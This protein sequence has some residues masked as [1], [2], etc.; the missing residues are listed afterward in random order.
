LIQAR[1]QVRI[2]NRIYREVIPRELTW[3]TQIRITHEQAWYLTPERRLDIAKLLAAFQQFFRE[4]SDAWIEG[5]SFK[6][7]GPQLLLQAFLQR[8]VNGGGRINREYGL[9]RK[10]TDL[11][12]E[13]PVD[14]EQGFL[15][16]VQ[17]VVLELKLWKK[18]AL[19]ALIAEGQ[20]Q[21]VDYAR[22]C[23]ADEAHLIVFDR[24]AAAAPWD[25]RIWQ[26][27]ATQDGWSLG[28]WGA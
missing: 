4:N 16:E 14:E 2:A 20:T 27:S 23:G 25:E 22:Q 10:R 5:F 7:A 17:R 13:W 12:I 18:G 19:E 6:E 3:T 24:R 21:T 9:G 8:I 26:R 15:G 28:L 11:Y 1:P